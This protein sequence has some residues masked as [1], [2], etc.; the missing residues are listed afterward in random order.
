MTGLRARVT[1]V[2]STG[3]QGSALALALVF[4]MVFGLYVGTVLEFATTGVRSAVAVSE[5]AV[6]TYAGGGA[7]DAAINEISGSLAVGVDPGTASPPSAST[8]F[9]LP[10][11]QLANPAPITV[12]CQPQPGS[13]AYVSGLESQPGQSVLAL[14]TDPSEGVILTGAAKVKTSGAVYANKVVDV[15]AGATLTS[16]DPIKAGDCSRALGSVSPVCTVAS[17]PGDPGWPGPTAYPPVVTTLPA[18]TDPGPV[19]TFAPGT[20]LSK[21]DLQPLFNCA[22]KVVWFE[23]GVYYF[24]FRDGGTNGDRLVIDNGDVV[25]GGTPDGWTP[26]VTAPGAVPLPTAGPPAASACKFDAQGVD[27][28]F[29]GDSRFEIQNNGRLQL[30]AEEFGTSQQ[31]IVVRGLSTESAALPAAAPTVLA[32][33]SGGGGAG[34]AWTTPGN[35]AVVDTQLTSVTVPAGGTSQR[36]R[37]TGFPKLAVPPEATSVDLTF[38]VTETLS[39]PGRATL[40]LRPK[41]GSAL[42]PMTLHDCASTPCTDSAFVAGKTDSITFPGLTPAQVNE[43]SVDLFV[44]SPIGGPT[45]AWVDGVVASASFTAKMRP[46][47]PLD[48]PTGTCAAGVTSTPVLKATAAALLALHGTVATALASVDL[49]LKNVGYPVVDRGLVVRTVSLSMT[50]AAGYTKPLI[51]IPPLVQDR[52]QVV[53][54]AVDASGTL[55]RALV[56]FSDGPA[57]TK[58]GT[59]ATVLEWVIS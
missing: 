47:C 39:G 36:M 17:V 22:G 1:G 51:S 49:G 50:P 3:D 34:P 13:G 26:G 10:A 55:A 16:S 7:L 23:P 40:T 53:M 46:T 6:N 44:T 59:T 5:E 28:V 8:C 48:P 56:S 35:G 24:D 33:T 2:R 9:T 38:K 30:C 31:H 37:L 54:T 14:S 57:G 29:G 18:C 43:M 58:N 20:Y 27:F 12:S 4:M 19:V 32:T 41:T 25:V 42:A 15:P 21:S 45:R 52:R 11:M